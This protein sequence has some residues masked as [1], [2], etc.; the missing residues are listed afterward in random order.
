MRDLTGSTVRVLG[1]ARRRKLL[2]A[3]FVAATTMVAVGCTSSG[4]TSSADDPSSARESTAIPQPDLPGD[5]PVAPDSKRVDLQVPKFSHP[6]HLH[7]N[8]WREGAPHALQGKRARAR[9]R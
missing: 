2:L 4:R 8:L 1:R 3:G 5:I 6:T 9:S 7:P